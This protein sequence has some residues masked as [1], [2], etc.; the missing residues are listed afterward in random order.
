MK[1]SA[2]KSIEP[3]SFSIDF[4]GIGSGKCGSTW[5]YDNLVQHPEICD[6]NL[7]E[8]NYFSDL[9]DAHPLSWYES[10]FSG[11]QSQRIRGEFSVTYI[12]HPKAAERIY[13]NFPET[14]LLAIVRNP[15]KRAFSNYLHSIRKGDI[16]ANLAFV[17]YIEDENR[18]APGR[19][20]E[21]LEPFY[22]LFDPKQIKV[23]VTED[24]A[25]DPV[26]GYGEI[27]K[28]IGVKDTHFMPQ[29][30]DAQRNVARS[31]RFLWLENILV[32]SYRGLC[33]RG[34]TRLVKKITES[35]IADRVRALNQGNETV[36]RIDSA[37]R[38]KLM[39]YYH[40]YN[41]QLETLLGRSLENWEK[42]FN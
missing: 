34:Y 17:D 40:P 1:T 4:I 37:S 36:P 16:P 28:Y 38:E 25:R 7:K 32:R 15:V 3:N 18:L 33:K 27:F 29:G 10:Q 39:A 22:K 9:Y 24:L 5:L 12:T 23:I 20:V 42:P 19:Y 21:H 11:C 41:K 35:G 2:V 8:L 31:Y 13:Q 14:R 30:Y 26:A 6:S